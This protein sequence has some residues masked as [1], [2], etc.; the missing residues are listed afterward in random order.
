MLHDVG[1]ETLFV[2]IMEVFRNTSIGCRARVENFNEVIIA[3]FK[4]RASN[5][6]CNRCLGV[7]PYAVDEGLDDVPEILSGS[8]AATPVQVRKL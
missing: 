6:Y 2:P 5:Q 8:A 7:H 1:F 4:W 3:W